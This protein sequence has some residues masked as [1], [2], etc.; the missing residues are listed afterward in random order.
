MDEAHEHRK[1][2]ADIR[3]HAHRLTAEAS[4]AAML[5]VAD[6]YDRLAAALEKTAKRD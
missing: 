4:R 1:R 5:S 6:N 2:A 3:V